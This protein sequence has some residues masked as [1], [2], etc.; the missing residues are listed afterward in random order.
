MENTTEENPTFESM[1]SNKIDSEKVQ[2]GDV[3]VISKILK[4]NNNQFVTEKNKNGDRYS[5]ETDKG[6]AWLNWTSVKNLR[7]DFGDNTGDWK[8]KK[9]KV[10]KQNALVNGQQRI[11]LYFSKA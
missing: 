5:M 1:I 6:S 2:G 7:N 3:F 4:H 11:V 10:V 8:G 9:V